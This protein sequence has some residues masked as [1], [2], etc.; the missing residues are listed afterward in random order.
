MG[1]V[2]FDRRVEKGEGK[3]QLKKSG[4]PAGPGCAKEDKNIVGNTEKGRE[5][6]AGS[7]PPWFA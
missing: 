4:T 2:F 7:I 1:R 5:G 3:V 6:V